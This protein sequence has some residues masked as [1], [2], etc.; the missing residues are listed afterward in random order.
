MEKLRVLE[1]YCGIGGM[2]YALSESNFS[3][4]I[5]VVA[6]IDIN[7]LANKVYKHNFKET[8]HLEKNLDG[9]NLQQFN[10]LKFD[11]LVMSPPCQP[12][13]RVGLK[14]DINDP[15][16]K[17]FLHLL[18]ILGQLESPPKY[19]LLENVKGFE[20]SLACK[21]FIK[22]LENLSFNFQSF[23]LSPKQL[24]IPNSRLRYYM[25][26]RSTSH[27]NKSWHDHN[28]CL[29]SFPS[30]TKLDKDTE[31]QPISNYLEESSKIFK[32]KSLLVDDKTRDRYEQVM[33][34]VTPQSTS[35]TCFTKA[36]AKY[37][38]GTGSVITD[39]DPQ[40]PKKLRYFSSREVANLMGFPPEF[41]FPVGME[42]RQRC[43]LLGN[44]LNVKVVAELMNLLLSDLS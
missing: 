3:A 2:H 4:F 29:T 10:K 28:N 20:E 15:R 19:I 5:Q 16:C 24:G 12:F 8:C 14:K 39:F 9:F 13:T 33:D 38:E 43:R 26:A 44:S 36:Y 11:V 21:Q 35:S 32:D 6:A 31:C 42:M 41:E 30:H 37:C 23:L 27:F 25:I 1:L 18:D 34:I 7:P 40:S 17:S 22:T